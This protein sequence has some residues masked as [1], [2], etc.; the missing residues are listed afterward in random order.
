MGLVK[1]ANLEN[2]T[3]KLK[4][5]ILYKC[6]KLFLRVVAVCMIMYPVVSLNWADKLVGQCKNRRSDKMNVK[7]IIM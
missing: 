5:S 6:P 1:K 4:R 7:I 2:K 3:Y